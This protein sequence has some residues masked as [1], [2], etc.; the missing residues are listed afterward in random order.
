MK[1][2]TVHIRRHGLDI[3]Q[4]LVLIKEGFSFWA[5]LLNLVWALWNKLWWVALGI[6]FLSIFLNILTWALAVD[7]VSSVAISIGSAFLIGLIANDLHRWTLDQRGYANF[8]VITGE[9]EDAALSRF[10]DSSPNLAQDL[11]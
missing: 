4:D 10:L 7:P 6:G 3:D 2:Y 1:V 9:T 8:G 5:F 11:I